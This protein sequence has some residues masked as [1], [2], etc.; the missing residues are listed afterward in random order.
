[1]WYPPWFDSYES[2]ILSATCGVVISCFFVLVRIHKAL[3]R[4]EEDVRKRSERDR[5]NEVDQDTC[6]G[7]RDV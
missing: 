7:K 3:R 6:D 2:W 4:I 5:E 1:M